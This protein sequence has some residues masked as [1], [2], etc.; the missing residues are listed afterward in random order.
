MYGQGLKPGALSSY[1]SAGFSLCTGY[2]VG[3]QSEEQPPTTARAMLRKELR[4][5][6]DGAAA[7]VGWS[8]AV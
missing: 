7:A 2:T 8:A 5:G 6:D 4:M 1:G 3:K